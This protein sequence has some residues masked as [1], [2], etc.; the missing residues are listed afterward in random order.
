[1]R[2]GI[3]V[4]IYLKKKGKT[5]KQKKLMHVHTL[6]CSFKHSPQ[7]DAYNMITVAQKVIAP[8]A[9]LRIY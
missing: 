5:N 6:F 3:F 7:F 9:G 4:L 2:K 8:P 1:M